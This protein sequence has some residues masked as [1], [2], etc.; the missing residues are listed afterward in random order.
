MG[1]QFILAHI[2]N[3]RDIIYDTRKALLAIK[4][5]SH[6]TGFQCIISGNI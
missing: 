2:P 1:A 4:K 5:E 6:A 3:Y